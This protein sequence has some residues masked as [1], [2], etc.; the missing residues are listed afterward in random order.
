M[1]FKLPNFYPFTSLPAVNRHF[2]K[3]SSD[4]NFEKVKFSTRSGQLISAI[5]VR[6]HQTF[7]NGH[8]LSADNGNPSPIQYVFSEIQSN[9]QT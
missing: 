5:L 6:I 4:I 8:L 9:A 2:F 3:G 7:C 1:K